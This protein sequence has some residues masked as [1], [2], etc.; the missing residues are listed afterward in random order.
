MRS[1]PTHLYTTLVLA[2]AC[3]A[4][5]AYGAD[6]A[7]EGRWQLN[8]EESDK[9]AVKYTKGSGTGRR[10]LIQSG[11]VSIG[12]LPLPSLGGRVPSQSRMAPKNPEVLLC[13]V[14]A[15]EADGNRLTLVYDDGEKEIMRKGDYRGR[16]SEWG[17]KGIRQNYKT[18]DRKVTKTWSI[19]KDG[20]LLVE[21]KL[22]PPKDRARTYK[23]V[24]D[25]VPDPIPASTAEVSDQVG[26]NTP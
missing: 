25:L 20:R 21:V 1:R 8:L 5:S 11:T 2:I 3:F 9:I 6:F 17:K 14:M 19:R 12:G 4:G 26:S 18:P 23:R 16:T 24:F 10:N 7:L 22:N 13:N 15:I